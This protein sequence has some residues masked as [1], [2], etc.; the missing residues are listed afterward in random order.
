MGTGIPC[1]YYNIKWGLN[2]WI[3][4]TIVCNYMHCNLIILQRFGS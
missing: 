4:E 3:L 1:K 2:I